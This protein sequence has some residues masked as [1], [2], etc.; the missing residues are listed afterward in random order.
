VD[1]VSIVIGVI[2][3]V[4]LGLFLDVDMFSKKAADEESKVDDHSPENEGK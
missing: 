4:V 1:V 2:I 3:G